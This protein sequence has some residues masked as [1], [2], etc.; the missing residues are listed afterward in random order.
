MLSFC[1]PKCFLD[2]S[3]LKAPQGSCSI[4]PF[5]MRKT[6]DYVVEWGLSP[7]GLNRKAHACKYSALLTLPWL[8]KKDTI[9]NQWVYT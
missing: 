1:V 2:I 8:M 6:G 3:S 7:G 9:K 5:T 4:P